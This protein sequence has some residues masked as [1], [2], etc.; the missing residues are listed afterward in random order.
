MSGSSLTVRGPIAFDSVPSIPWKNGG[1]TTR[2]L[3]AEPE[4]AELDDFVWRIS[5]AEIRTSGDFS[6]FPNVD[7]TILLWRG[8]GVILRSSAWP[9]HAL[10][11]LGSPFGFRG[12][13]N[14]SCELVGESTSDLNLMVRRGSAR[15]AIHTASAE[16]RLHDPYDDVVVL[17]ASG[18]IQILFADE[19]QAAL[20]ADHFLRISQPVAGIRIVPDGVATF[21]YAT[22][23]MLR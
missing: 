14:V 7:R 3:V 20:A 5:L 19:L 21:V 4:D 23:Q 10:T 8:E 13:E 1:G 16:V 6:V 11:E 12:E 9:Q 15:G 17:C 18:R 2:T 22:L